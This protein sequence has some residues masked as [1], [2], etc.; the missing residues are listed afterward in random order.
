MHERSGKLKKVLPLAAAVA[1]IVVTGGLVF[2][3]GVPSPQAISIPHLFQLDAP[4]AHSVSVVGD[5][6]DWDP[7]AQPLTRKNGVWQA[8]VSLRKGRTYFYNFIIDGEKWITDPLQLLTSEDSFGK[9]SVLE[10]DD[11][12]EETP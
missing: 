1:F 10:M 12:G 9:K 11:A 3:Q 7:A 2:L 8:V 6:N 5:F 4:E